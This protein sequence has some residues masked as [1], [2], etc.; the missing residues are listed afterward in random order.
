MKIILEKHQA[1]A[2]ALGYI[3]CVPILLFSL[4]IFVLPETVPFGLDKSK[5]ENIRFIPVIA[6]DLVFNFFLSHDKLF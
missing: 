6:A 3:G 2:F 5:F 1:A 4:Y